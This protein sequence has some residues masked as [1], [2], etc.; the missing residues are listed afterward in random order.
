[1]SPVPATR[2]GCETVQEHGPRTLPPSAATPSSRSR[3]PAAP[4][5]PQ[6]ERR[7]RRPVAAR[8]ETR[9]QGGAP[10][11]PSLGLCEP[12]GK[13]RHREREGLHECLCPAAHLSSHHLPLSMSP[14]LGT[15]VLPPGPPLTKGPGEMRSRTSWLWGTCSLPH[16]CRHVPPAQAR[17]TCGDPKAEPKWSVSL[18]PRP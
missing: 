13:L 5:R 11:S 10:V 6:T 18:R 4:R 7:R 9:S 14:P 3:L 17:C 8:P 16:L 15:L 2:V 12:V 1:M